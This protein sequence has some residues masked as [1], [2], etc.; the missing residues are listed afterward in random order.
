MRRDA[1]AISTFIVGWLEEQLGQQVSAEAEFAALGIDSLDAVRLTDS[2][3][4]QLGIDDLPVALMLEHPSIPAL[5]TH[6]ATL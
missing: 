6:L 2:L 4:A 1:K 5:S 3:A